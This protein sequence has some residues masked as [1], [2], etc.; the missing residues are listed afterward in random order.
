[1]AV[2][3]VKTFNTFHVSDLGRP[4]ATD[5]HVSHKR[6]FSLLAGVGARPTNI[7]E[8][9][10]KLIGAEVSAE[11]A[12]VLTTSYPADAILLLSHQMDRSVA[13]ALH[14]KV[15]LH[16]HTATRDAVKMSLGYS[17]DG[18]LF[19]HDG[20]VILCK[21]AKGLRAYCGKIAGLEQVQRE[22]KIARLLHSRV[23]APT[24][25]A[26]VDCVRTT[27]D[28]G[29]ATVLDKGALIMPLLAMTV[30]DLIAAT[31]LSDIDV[32]NI[33]MCGLA[34]AYAFFLAN[35]LHMDL[36]PGNMMLSDSG[37]VQTIDFD[38]CL[39]R[40]EG[41]RRTTELYAWFCAPMDVN[42]LFDVHFL[43][44][45]LAVIIDKDVLCTG[46]ETDRRA[47]AMGSLSARHDH[48]PSRFALLCLQ[49]TDVH[50][51]WTAAAQLHSQF[52]EGAVSLEA[53]TPTL[54]PV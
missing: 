49:S 52:P 8:T 7:F 23:N 4:W 32:L 36:K 16:I 31:R 28:Q 40:G 39:Q 15:Q 3:L 44:G 47:A 6:H 53:I 37:I 38:S 50:A 9:W 35:M 5:E 33:G 19:V 13:L 54:K 41:I 18:R 20:S 25:V 17:F 26:V 10:S 42:P 43:G 51:T 34:T 12:R 22:A 2:R 30:S 29:A 48:M 11:D 46:D 45:V 21:V 1:M 27:T 14:A 24:V